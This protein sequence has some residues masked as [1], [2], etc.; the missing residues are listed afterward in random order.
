MVCGGGA[1]LDGGGRGSGGFLLKFRPPLTLSQRILKSVKGDGVPLDGTTFLSAALILLPDFN[2]FLTERMLPATSTVTLMSSM[3]C[4]NVHYCNSL[5]VAKVESEVLVT[6]LNHSNSWGL[7]VDTDSS[8]VFKKDYCKDKL[9]QQH[10]QEDQINGHLQ[11]DPQYYCFPVNTTQQV[12]ETAVE[13]P[14]ALFEAANGFFENRNHSM[15]SIAIPKVEETSPRGYVVSSTSASDLAPKLARHLESLSEAK[16]NATITPVATTVSL[17]DVKAG[18]TVLHT[19]N[20]NVRKFIFHCGEGECGFSSGHRDRFVIHLR[21][22]H[23]LRVDEKVLDF[24]NWAAFI[25]WKEYLEKE[26]YASF[27]KPH[28]SYRVQY[29]QHQNLESQFF[30]CAWLERSKQLHDS[31]N[32]IKSFRW[33]PCISHLIARRSVHKGRVSVYCVLS[34]Y[35][36]PIGPGIY[37]GLIDFPKV[38]RSRSFTGST[39]QDEVKSISCSTIVKDA[40]FSHLTAEREPS[41]EYSIFRL[42]PIFNADLGEYNAT[43]QMSSATENQ[44]YIHTLRTPSTVQKQRYRPEAASGPCVFAGRAKLKETAKGLGG[45]RESDVEIDSDFSLE[46]SEGEENWDSVERFKTVLRVIRREGRIVHERMRVYVSKD[47]DSFLSHSRPSP[48]SSARRSYF[49]CIDCSM[50]GTHLATTNRAEFIKHLIRTHS[51][52]PEE[53]IYVFQNLDKFIAFKLLMESKYRCTFVLHRKRC[54]ELVFECSRSG[55]YRGENATCGSWTKATAQ[56]RK[57]QT[58][59][60][61]SRCTARMVVIKSGS[62]RTEAV[63]ANVC[64]THYGHKEDGDRLNLSRRL[65]LR[66]AQMACNSAKSSGEIFQTLAGGADSGALTR[67]AVKSVIGY[68]RRN[69]RQFD[70]PAWQKELLDVY[71]T[72]FSNRRD[73]CN[74]AVCEM[75]EDRTL[76][77]EKSIRFTRIGYNAAKKTTDWDEGFLLDGAAQISYQRVPSSDLRCYRATHIGTGSVLE[78]YDSILKTDEVNQLSTLPFEREKQDAFEFQSNETASTELFKSPSIADYALTAVAPTTHVSSNKSFLVDHENHPELSLLGGNDS[79]W[80]GSSEGSCE[81]LNGVDEHDM[82]HEAEEEPHTVINHFDQKPVFTGPPLHMAAKSR[83]VRSVKGNVIVINGRGGFANRPEGCVRSVNASQTLREE[84]ETADI[85]QTDDRDSSDVI[86]HAEVTIENCRAPMEKVACEDLVGDKMTG[87]L[88]ENEEVASD[89]LREILDEGRVVLM[90]RQGAPHPC[91]NTSH[92][93]KSVTGSNNTISNSNGT[94]ATTNTATTT[95]NNNSSSNNSSGSETNRNQVSQSGQGNSNRILSGQNNAENESSA[96]RGQ[97]GQATATVKAKEKTVA[98]GKIIEARLKDTLH[99]SDQEQALKRS[100]EQAIF[101]NPVRYEPPRVVP[102]PT[103]APT[104]FLNRKGSSSEEES[105]EGEQPEVEPPPPPP[106]P[107]KANTKFGKALASA[108]RQQQQQQQP[109][110]Q[111]VSITTKN[112]TSVIAEKR[113]I[114][115]SPGHQEDGPHSKVATV[116]KKT[117]ILTE[118]QRAHEYRDRLMG[119]LHPS[120][121][122]KPAPVATTTSVVVKAHSSAVSGASLLASGDVSSPLNA[123]MIPRHDPKAPSPSGSTPH[124]KKK[125]AVQATDRNNQSNKSK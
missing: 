2:S 15:I 45:I 87:V 10:E 117:E 9:L 47:D 113:K 89:L 60:P 33:R 29:Y 73:Y 71:R 102:A 77:N 70:Y 110:G 84:H 51:T 103:P 85:L 43:S 49:T 55:R 12:E 64:V 4:G 58:Q 65:A 40:T 123:I 121:L 66:V 105:S 75:A 88:I 41:R 82:T 8:K 114:T 122:I 109:K 34:H 17:N 5:D 119:V 97:G 83:A 106:K 25:A 116:I 22:L 27:V 107:S 93:S 39:Q 125:L 67:D 56:N 44:V 68:V 50:A 61:R 59:E 79:D 74:G 7:K 115:P 112:S 21:C 94:N 108:Q 76:T 100:I 23:H 37:P 20:S 32:L 35:G 36:H 104:S 11:S 95:T 19:V 16:L 124:G 111:F 52:R 6:M 53:N 28:P 78:G 90:A 86:A 24:N 62:G 54:N 48:K 120:A 63:Q 99:L 101:T 30:H 98:V 72:D 26:T 69:G 31:S 42:N 80:E 14:P 57:G 118:A 13:D 92:S 96:A 46:G 3:I 38:R 81:T 1:G 18:E 91:S